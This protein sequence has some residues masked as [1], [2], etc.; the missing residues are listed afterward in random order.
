M[1][2]EKDKLIAIISSFPKGKTV[3]LLSYLEKAETNTITAFAQF[4]DLFLDWHAQ[5]VASMEIAFSKKA[6][7][8]AG[9]IC[10]PKKSASSAENGKKGGR[11]IK[12]N[13][14]NYGIHQLVERNAKIGVAL[15][16]KFL[17][18]SEEDNYLA[19]EQGQVRLCSSGS[20]KNKKQWWELF[21]AGETVKLSNLSQG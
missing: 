20:R 13:R 19:G 3:D 11:P 10:S 1:T 8:R 17:S 9:K 2:E 5:Q 12:V 4:A 7:S 21:I 15:E 16:D 18:L 6:T 14:V